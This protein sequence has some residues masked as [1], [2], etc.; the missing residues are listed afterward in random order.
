MRCI[1][2]SARGVMIRDIIRLLKYLK[3][4]LKMGVRDRTKI[5]YGHRD[6]PLYRAFVVR[7]DI[8]KARAILMKSPM[9]I[10]IKCIALSGSPF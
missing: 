8:F 6:D 1:T 10:E 5:S 9:R 7:M 2:S 4:K 3:G